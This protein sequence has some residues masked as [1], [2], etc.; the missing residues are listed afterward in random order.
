MTSGIFLAYTLLLAL[1]AII[2]VVMFDD[3]G[4]RFP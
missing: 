3:D 2:L 4:P 1:L